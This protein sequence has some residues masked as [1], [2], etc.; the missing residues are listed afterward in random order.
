MTEPDSEARVQA[1]PPG[2]GLRILSGLG[3]V[4][5]L[6]V[7]AVFTLGSALVAP[8]GMVGARI[9]ARR[10][11][12]P[13]TRVASWLGACIASGTVVLVGSLVVYF[14]MP[15]DTLTRI[16]AA[17]DSARTD[18]RAHPP[19][20]LEPMRR[21]APPNP[22]AERLAESRPLTDA[23]MIIGAVLA[24]EIFGTFAGS[25]GWLGTSLILYAF[26]RPQSSR[27]AAA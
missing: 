21:I 5:V 4:V 11:G 27:E 2:A 22:A 17:A 8:V 20:W 3:G 6:I 12:R 15:P 19:A 18:A 10:Q 25:A 9:L 16:E 7:S 23:F 24:I 14:S 13:T 1:H 26:R